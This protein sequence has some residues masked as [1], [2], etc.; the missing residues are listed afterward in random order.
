MLESDDTARLVFPP[1]HDAEG[2]IA[3]RLKLLLVASLAALSIAYI[4]KGFFVGIFTGSSDVWR[5]RLE[6]RFVLREHIDTR[7]AAS[8]IRRGVVYPPWSY[9]SG[10]LLF[11]PPWPQV[12]VW[13]ALVNFACLTWII[14]FVVAYARDQPKLDRLLVVLSVTAIAAFCTTIGVGNYGVIVVALLVGAYQAEEAG[15]PVL[16][17]LLMGVALLKPQ[18]AGPFL[19]V[20]LVRGRF[21]ALAAAAIYL[22]VAST[23]IWMLSGT[24]PVRM[25]LQ[26]ARFAGVFANTTN[27]LLTLVLDVGVPYRLAAPLTAIVCLAIFTPL[28]WTNRERSPMLLFAIAAVTSRLWT[29]NLNTSNLILVFLLL[30]L[31]RL[32]I[33]TRVVRAGVLFLAVGASLWVPARLSECHAIQ[34]A[35]H[36]IWLGGVVGLLI[37]DRRL[38]V[39]DAS[40]TPCLRAGAAAVVGD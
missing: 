8:F 30:A 5:R 4:G 20:A 31:W 1:G 9:L 13:F 27:G 35:E 37:L 10:A 28:L 16:S 12:R 21:R 17:G 39:S 2:R 6:E 3:R 24:D 40:A 38:V 33:E 11:W 22:I 34:L 19:L 14:G 26:S 32:A 23:A 25:L 29:Y 36:L 7:I 18:L 15:R